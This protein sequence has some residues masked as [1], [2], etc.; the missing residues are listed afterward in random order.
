MAVDD[1][2]LVPGTRQLSIFEKNG[3]TLKIEI[4]VKKIITITI[5]YYTIT[6]YLTCLKAS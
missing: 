3:K 1:Y 2:C 5:L 6:N 4:T